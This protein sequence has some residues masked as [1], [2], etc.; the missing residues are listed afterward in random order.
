MMKIHRTNFLVAAA[1]VALL[2]SA[3]SA[4][5]I[6]AVPAP[7]SSGPGLGFASVPVVVTVQQ[8]NDN[9]PAPQ[10]LDN[11]IT[12]ALKRFEAANYIDIVFNVLQSDGTTEY[13]VSEFVDNGTTIPWSSYRMELG[14]GTGTSFAINPNADDLDFDFP[15]YDLPPTSAAFPIVSTPNPDT[16]V[17]SGGL[18]GTDAQPY[19]FRIDVPDGIQ[20]FTLRQIPTLVPEPSA[21]ML[22]G[23]VLAG[24]AA[25][26]RRG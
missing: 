11:N 1:L 17:F 25:N 14:F 22:V 5:T 7:T 21:I 13:Q 26:R 19:A 9:V 8:N 23:F 12:V 2:G 10:F 18:H 16:L 3:A 4:G 24:F 20:T 15:N 6:Q